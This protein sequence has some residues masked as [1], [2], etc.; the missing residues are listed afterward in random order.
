[1]THPIRTNRAADSLRNIRIT[2]N[3]LPHADGSVLIECGNTKVICTASIDENVPPF[4][5]GKEQG[6]V[7]A[8]YGMLPASTAS[9]M[10]REAASG[11][12]SGR[13]QEIQRLIGRSLRAVVDMKK[14]GE[15]QILIDCDVIQADGGTRT[16]SITGAY[17]ALQMAVNKLLS[18]GLICE[19]PILEAVAAVSVGVVAGVPLLDLDYPEDSGCDSDVNIVM[20][21]SGKII[22]I[23]G[24][25]EGAPFTLDELGKL[26]ALGQK[27]IAELVQ[28][29]LAALQA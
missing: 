1:M 12:Q 11:K 14:L 9:R 24:T 5:R 21:A 23:Q 22:E 20:T 10:R 26:I 17:V 3:F 18:D 4:L 29:Q 19:T 7:T 8:E 25:A 27:G 15:R 28:H 13:T 16:A 2:P 6:W